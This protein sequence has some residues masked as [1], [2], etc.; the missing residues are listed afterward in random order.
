MTLRM[1]IHMVQI[2]YSYT[3]CHNMSESCNLYLF[4]NHSACYSIT[5][6]MLLYD[7]I[8]HLV[9]S[10]YEQINAYSQCLFAS[11]AC[12]FPPVALVGIAS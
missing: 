1:Y 3:F 4:C 10:S 6:L 2:L 8:T 5:C 11:R 9:P 12:S 7:F